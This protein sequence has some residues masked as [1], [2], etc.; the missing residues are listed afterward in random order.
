MDDINKVINLY[1]EQCPAMFN[2]GWRKDLSLLH[3][4]A[5]GQKLGIDYLQKLRDIYD[6]ER[7]RQQLIERMQD[8]SNSDNSYVILFPI[9]NHIWQQF[10]CLNYIVHCN[11]I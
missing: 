9:L 5:I 4:V 6:R 2:T 3:I 11:W 7:I 1:K 10:Y 8:E